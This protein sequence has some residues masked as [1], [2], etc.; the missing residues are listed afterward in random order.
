MSIEDVEE[1]KNYKLNNTENRDSSDK[2]K[3]IQEMPDRD[4]KWFVRHAFGIFTVLI[5]YIFF[6]KIYVVTLIFTIIPL[7]NPFDIIHAIL[8]SILATMAIWSH[9]V[10]MT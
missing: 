8:F 7:K 4:L 1:R 9:S 5:V 3:T 2:S 6:I 10:S